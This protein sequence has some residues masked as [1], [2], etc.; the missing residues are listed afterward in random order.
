MQ[1]TQEACQY[2]SAGCDW[3]TLTA[4]SDEGK[5]NLYAGSLLLRDRAAREGQLF[6]TWR[7]NGYVG[8]AADHCVWA[9]RRDSHIVRLQ[10]AWAQTYAASFLACA[11]NVPRVDYAVTVKLAQADTQVAKRLYLA[12]L[13]HPKRGGRP[14]VNTL[15]ES[16]NG[17]S[18]FYLGRRSSANFARV[19]DKGVESGT[20]AA[21]S[22]WRY[23][24]ELKDPVAQSSVA[25]FQR[26]GA[27]VVWV[28]AFVHSWFASRGVA[29]PWSIDRN[30]SLPETP[31]ES[32]AQ[33]KLEWL[34]RSVRPLAMELMEVFGREAV[35]DA[36][37]V[38]DRPAY[39]PTDRA[40]TPTGAATCQQQESYSARP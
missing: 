29:C 38:T 12:L 2:V 31:R 16:T 13:S 4:K 5:E 17:G 26:E 34:R 37:G 22:L 33:R 23:E 19:Y 24:L 21:G 20:A 27:S 11:E 1:H 35:A 32:S 8:W 6:R 25:E 30:V 36:L 9:E 15:V 10:S 14:T 7:A 3:L 39:F 28:A 40:N 18:T